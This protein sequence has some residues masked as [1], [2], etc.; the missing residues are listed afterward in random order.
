MFTVTGMSDFGGDVPYPR[1]RCER[2]VVMT[3]VGSRSVRAVET[4]DA[5]L[6]VAERLYAEKGLHAVS[7][8][9]VSE[10]AGQGN[11][12]AVG[13]HFGTKVDLIRAIVEKHSAEI[14]ASRTEMVARMGES[15]E[16]RGWVECLIRPFTNH[17]S[18][19]GSPSWYGRFI[20]QVVADPALRSV[21]YE[22]AVASVSL[23]TTRDGLNRCLPEL[24]LDVRRSRSDM[25]RNVLMNMC[26]ERETEFAEQ[27][28]E[29]PANWADCGTDL[30]DATVGMW[31]APVTRR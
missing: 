13:Y 29:R 21:A 26:A 17:L 11:N 27:H 9:Q 18:N 12:A 30:I 16:L 2:L 20:L 15:D 14:E 28:P 31:Q 6:N 10:A 4:R 1:N 22:H 19:L 7:N 23:R 5:I 24:P 3:S 25:A 8:R